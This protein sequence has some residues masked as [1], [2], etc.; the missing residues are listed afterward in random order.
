MS[1]LEAAERALV[2][3]AAKRIAKNRQ[4]ADVVFDRCQ[5]TS[6]LA[7][8][9]LNHVAYLLRLPRT[10]FLTSVMLELTNQCNLKCEF[11]PTAK[12]SR[13][14]GFMD[15]GLA[16]RVLG[17][18]K[19]LQYVYLYDWGEPLLHPQLVRIVEIA[20]D[21]GHRT[22]LVTNGTLL[23]KQLGERLI[24]AGLS[25]VAFSIDGLG[26]TYS[27]LRGFDYD[28]LERKVLDFLRTRESLNPSLRVEI[29]FVVSP[30][31]ECEVERFRKVWASRVDYISFQ[32][33][34]SYQ[35]VRRRLPCR[36]LWKGGLVV[37]W[38][39][40]VVACCVDY[41]GAN[42]VGN[43][44]SEPL[45]KILNSKRMVRMRRAQAKGQFYGICRS[46]SEFESTAFDGRFDG[47]LARDSTD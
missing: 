39:G 27:R 9:A 10:F 29:N 42:V 11:C 16:K 40:T 38:D 14:R 46:C 31:T 30:E 34:L 35:P 8:A 22:F 37:L 6:D 15:V 32:P 45:L 41:D 28:V 3:L 25:A 24:R 33:M 12:M 19:N 5:T 23:T 4:L 47:R 36:E 20:S 26:Q 17:Q 13:A 1:W 18:C 44:N 43:A 2:R 21:F 7:R